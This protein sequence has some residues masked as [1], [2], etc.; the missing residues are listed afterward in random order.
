MTIILTSEDVFPLGSHLLLLRKRRK[1]LP[2]LTTT[3]QPPL[4]SSEKTTRLER[5]SFSSECVQNTPLQ[6]LPKTW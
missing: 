6:I 5:F 3:H 4:A 1:I 2:A